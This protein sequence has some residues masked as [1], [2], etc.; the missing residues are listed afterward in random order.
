MSPDCFV[1]YNSSW[2]LTGGPHQLKP[3]DAVSIFKYYSRPYPDILDKILGVDTQL[4][5]CNTQ[6]NFQFLQYDLIRRIKARSITS[7]ATAH[8]VVLLLGGVE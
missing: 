8:L 6:L 7:S 3:F 5:L 4:F 2:E 1:D